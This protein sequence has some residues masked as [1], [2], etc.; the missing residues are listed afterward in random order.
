MCEHLG[1]CLNVGG[2]A[3]ETFIRTVECHKEGVPGSE[4]T[5]ADGSIHLLQFSCCRVDP[6]TVSLDRP[7]TASRQR[8]TVPMTVLEPSAQLLGSNSTA[9]A[10]DSQQDRHPEQL[11]SIYGSEA[12]QQ[13]PQQSDAGQQLTAQSGSAVSKP[14][15]LK[16]HSRPMCW[17]HTTAILFV[18]TIPA[19]L[20]IDSVIKLQI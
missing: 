5:K 16:V 11:T 4:E 1:L 6:G 2:P 8:G 9:A 12:F 14:I 7:S 17:L 10:A 20:C 18:L 3:D 13:G 15:P 19:I